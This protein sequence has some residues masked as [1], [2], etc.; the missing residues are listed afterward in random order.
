MAKE[1][2]N[3]AFDME[4]DGLDSK[5][6]H[7]IVTQ[8]LDTGL[9]EEYNDEKYAEDPKGLPMAS[10]YS[11]CNGLSSIMACDNIVSHNGIAYDVAQAQKHYPFFRELNAKHWDTLILSRFYH[12]NLLEIDLKR[13]WSYMPA[14]LY[15]SHSLEA[16]G[17]RLKCYKGEF[18]KTTDWK[19]WSRE[20]QE[21]CKQ[22]VAVLVKLWEHFQ[23]YLNPSS[24]S[25][26]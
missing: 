1:K 13:K 17:Y 21:Y 4:T 19:E 7:C 24:L 20:M 15:G 8:D 6:I 16:Y 26:K 9:V 3:L 11:I 25:T 10:S 5:R 2:L 12:P 23:K 22:D 14:R 18:G